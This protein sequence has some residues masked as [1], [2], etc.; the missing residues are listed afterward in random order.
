[1]ATVNKNFKVKHG[2]VVEGTTGTI[3]GEDILTKAQAD[4]DY[5]IDQVGGS[6]VSE[7][8]PDTL[9]LRDE[10]GDFAANDVTVNELSI[11]EM[12]RIYEDD[13]DLIISN[14]DESDV[15]IEADDIRL[16]ATDDVRLTSGTGSDIVLSADSGTIRFEAPN[17]YAGEN[18]NYVDSEKVAT[19]GY[20][21]DAI[22]NIDLTYT[23]D[24]VTEGTNLYF[25]DT[26]AREAVSAGDGLDYNS[27]SGVFSADLG[28]GLQID[29]TG[30]IEI[31]NNVVATQTDLST[32]I[33]TH[34]DATSG[35]HGVTGD[36]VGTVDAQTLTNKTIGSG[37]TLSANLDANGFTVTGL[38]TPTNGT[39]AVT[40]Q[41][42]DGLS[43]G[44]SWKAAVNLLSST[45]VSLTGTDGTLVIDGHSALDSNDVGYRLLLTGQTTA[46]E[47]GIYDYTVSGGNYTLTRSADSDSDAELHGAAVFVMEGTAYGSTSWIQVNHYVAS[48]ANQEWDQFSGAGTYIAGNGLSLEGN[49]FSIDTD[50]TATK[51]Y[52]DEEIDAH[53][54]LTTAHGVA[55]DI[56]GT[57]DTQTLTSKTLGS[58]TVLGADLDGTN[59]YKVVNL[60]DPTSNQDAATKKYV[61]DEIASV[62]GT[63]DNLTTTDVAEGDNLYFTDIRAKGSAADLI[64]N[65][66]KTNI[67]ITGNEDG[68]TITAEN[69]VADS[70]TSDL[71]E[72]TNL[73]FTDYRARTAIIPGVGVSLN[74]AT[75]Y[76]DANLG[77]GLE[78]DGSNQIQID[79]TDVD[80]WYDA[81]GAA[82]AA[83]EAAED[84]ADGLAG[85]Y[86]VAGAAAA[87]QAAAEGYADGLAAN[88]D[89]AGSAATAETDAR[90]YAD[91]L[92]GDVTVDG[93]SGNT[94]TARIASAVSGLVDSAPELLNTLNELAEALQDNPDVISDLQDLAAG[95]Q[96]TLTAGA[97]IDITGATISVTGLDTDDVSEGTN[98]YF[99]DARAV[100]AL[101]AVVPNFT[102]VDI[103]SVATQVAATGSATAATAT[104][105]YSFAKADYRSAK[106]LVKVAYSTHTEISEVLL[107]LDT[108]DNIAITEYA[109]VGTNGTL[110]AVSAAVSGANVNLLVT[111]TNTSTVTV[112]GTLLA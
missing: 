22:G 55:G 32:D 61:D 98:L 64:V 49:E 38:A 4:V 46:T 26:R 92:I 112:M 88:Y 76:I 83:Q 109:I 52:V 8:T 21:D 11:K 16:N 87:A 70:T 18:L 80:T 97:N 13:G 69:G 82:A 72:G 24:D 94:V 59:A 107:T 39:D 44:L 110:S 34:S 84:Y 67:T 30:Q 25:T 48:F 51:S 20:V 93:T 15:I 89:P 6:G 86:E 31:D 9:V 7:N 5:I 65:A 68:L 99:T 85:N 29:G 17:I 78:T 23:T 33:G 28:N 108:S 35:V 63:L 90:N 58:G 43:A 73:Y 41:Y 47:N 57:S 3:N 96:D 56:V 10:N 37:T 71:A 100:D 19:R 45:N 91:E 66:I 105:V 40:K 111:P 77:T 60:V 62:S 1:M 53:T 74:T 104:T 54:E 102:E 103:N 95:K 2:L 106:F 75:G 79:R 50:V 27:T 12:G 81:N 36:V 14:T 101:E 42:V